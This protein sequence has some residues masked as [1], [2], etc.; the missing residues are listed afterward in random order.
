[1][2]FALTIKTEPTEYAVTKAELK[3]QLRI[4]GTDDDSRLDMIIPAAQAAIENMCRR[5]FTNTTYEM[6]LD[7][8]PGSEYD[9]TISLYRAPFSSVT[10]IKY[11][12]EN[13]DVQTL[14]TSLYLTDLKSI[15][16]RI[17]PAYGES[18]P[19]TQSINNAVTIEYVAGYGGSADVPKAL[20]MAVMGLCIDLY[21]HPES[22]AEI[23]LEMNKSVKL[24]IDRYIVPFVA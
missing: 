18:W 14:S 16:G 15:I 17:T 1:M 19:T 21:E 11:V 5:T 23:R 7:E 9:Y 20:K 4:D 6:F 24:L 8:F 12:D 3:E 22:S 10:S 2:N 13:G